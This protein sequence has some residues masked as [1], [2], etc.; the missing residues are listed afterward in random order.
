MSNLQSPIFK[1]LAPLTPIAVLFS[2]I[3]GYFNVIS[4]PVATVIRGF[5]QIPGLNE[6]CVQGLFLLG[7]YDSDELNRAIVPKIFTNYPNG[8]NIFIFFS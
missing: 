8:K 2:N 3:F 7:G 5:C 6:V 4:K 1:I